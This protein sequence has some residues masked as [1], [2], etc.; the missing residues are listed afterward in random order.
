LYSENTLAIH[1]P[2]N[3]KK[4]SHLF[5]A[6]VNFLLWNVAVGR[7]KGDAGGAEFRNCS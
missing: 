5:F 2:V 3:V 7:G 6:S 4:E 1:G